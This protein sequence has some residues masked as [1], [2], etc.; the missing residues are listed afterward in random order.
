MNETSID[1]ITA[2]REAVRAFGQQ[3][4]YDTTYMEVLM[5]ASPGAYLTFEAALGMGRYQ[6]AAPKELLLIAKLDIQGAVALQLI[7]AIRAFLFRSKL[8]VP[9]K[10]LGT[11]PNATVLDLLRA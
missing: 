2:S 10:A 9:G 8:L 1:R 7:M 3:Y 4:D 5:D 11:L 6:K